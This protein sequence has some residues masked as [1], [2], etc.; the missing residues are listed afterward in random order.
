MNE[1]KLFELELFGDSSVISEI[2]NLM[3]KLLKAWNL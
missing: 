1:A 3:C 2:R